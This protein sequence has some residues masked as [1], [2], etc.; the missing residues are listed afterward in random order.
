MKNSEMMYQNVSSVK[1]EVQMF[2]DYLHLG[3][4]C[5]YKDGCNNISPMQSDKMF[6]IK[7]LPAVLTLKLWKEKP[8]NKFAKADFYYK[9]IIDSED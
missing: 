4:S 3:G 8:V 6:T 5:R 2:T 1:D 7:Y 9:I